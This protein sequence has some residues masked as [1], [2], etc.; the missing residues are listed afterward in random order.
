MYDELNV[1]DEE[2]L[3]ALENIIRQKEKVVKHYNKKV[4][5]KS[6][7]IE[8]FVW[9]VILP[10]NKKSKNLVKWSPNW[11]WPYVIEKVLSGNAYAIQE[12]NTDRYIGSINGKYLKIYR[13]MITEINI[14]LT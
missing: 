13:P 11:D 8:D 5:K 1:L 14:P 4:K 10:M 7:Q 3:I 6:F 9:K 2:Y 12:V